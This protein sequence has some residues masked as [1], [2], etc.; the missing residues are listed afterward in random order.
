LL[1]GSNVVWPEM[2][3]ES[4]EG[5]SLKKGKTILENK[6]YGEQN[7]KDDKPFGY[8]L[9]DTIIYPSILRLHWKHLISSC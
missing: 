9:F 2:P 4:S 6:S 3:N 7:Y 8:K 5:C 1:L